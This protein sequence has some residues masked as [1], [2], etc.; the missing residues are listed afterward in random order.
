MKTIVACFLVLFLTACQT[1][2][3]PVY[4]VPEFDIPARPQLRSTETGTMDEMSKNVELD[5]IDVTT[6]AIQLENIIKTI[7]SY[8]PASEVT[9]SKNNK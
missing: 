8:K 2:Y 3:L 7:K 9:D 6:Y 5:L 4:T 1:V